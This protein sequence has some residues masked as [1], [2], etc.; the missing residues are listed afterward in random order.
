[1]GSRNTVVHVTLASFA[2]ALAVVV[3]FGLAA[4]RPSRAEPRCTHGLSSVGPV[5]FRDG[6]II[7]GDTTPPTEAC[8]R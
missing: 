3:L 6:K 2:C 4:A 7:G 5:Y 1:M 8:L